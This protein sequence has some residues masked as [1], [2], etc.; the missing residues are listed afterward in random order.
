MEEI[1]LD[2]NPEESQTYAEKIGFFAR[3]FG[4]W[5]SRISR[6][7]TVRKETYCVCLTCGARRRFDAEKLQPVG[8]FYNPPMSSLYPGKFPVRPGK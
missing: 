5:H 7:M 3:L 1:T 4:C 2:K 8:D 6:P